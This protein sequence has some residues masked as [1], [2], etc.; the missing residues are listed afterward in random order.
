LGQDDERRRPVLKSNDVS[1]VGY[2]LRTVVLYK[3]IP[4]PHPTGFVDVTQH[5]H[6]YQGS[7]ILPL[8]APYRLKAFG[9]CQHHITVVPR[10]AQFLCRDP[11]RLIWLAPLPHEYASHLLAGTHDDPVRSWRRLLQS[12]QKLNGVFQRA[13]S[14]DEHADIVPAQLPCR[15]WIER[16]LAESPLLQSRN[17]CSA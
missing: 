9:S 17:L 7:N 4:R 5:V 13:T 11:R 12:V 3:E 15:L 1:E 14:P 2:Q 16:E 8:S 10:Q 6:Q